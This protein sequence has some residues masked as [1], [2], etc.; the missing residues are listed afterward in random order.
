MESN[1]SKNSRDYWGNQQVRK[2][3]NAKFIE[4]FFKNHFLLLTI[5][6]RQ[7]QRRVEKI[8]IHRQA[9]RDE[10]LHQRKARVERRAFHKTL[11]ILSEQ[12]M[13]LQRRLK[14]KQM[15]CLRVAV[16]VRSFL[17]CNIVQTN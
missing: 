10:V 17:Q 11:V 13:E 4:L 3:L 6:R 5:R 14:C 7:V 16:V 1:S 2:K 15:Q 9:T 8:R 12:Q